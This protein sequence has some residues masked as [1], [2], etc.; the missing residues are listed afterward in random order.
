MAGT[1]SVA[2][3]HKRWLPWRACIDLH[4]AC[5]VNRITETGELHW[6]SALLSLQIAYLFDMYVFCDE[7][8]KATTALTE[9]IADDHFGYE[10]L[11]LDL[12]SESLGA[13]IQRIKGDT[14]EL[15]IVV[16][17]GDSNEAAKH[18][19]HILPAWPGQR[20][21]LTL[22]D[23]PNAGFHWD[24]MTML[25]ADEK[26][27]LMFLFPEDMDI[28]RNA[29]SEARMPKGESRYD[30]YFAEHET[31][32][33]IALDPSVQHT[34]PLLRALYKRD[35]ER[36]LDYQFFGA[37]DIRVSN[38]VGEI[39]TLLFCSKHVRGKELWDKVN[40]P[41]HQQD[42]LYPIS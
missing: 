32:R 20:Y 28:E 16:I 31:W 25:T 30:R 22:I 18:I 15:K 33:S 12:G 8:R 7:S 41:E 38:K 40:R 37:R 23:P 13:D 42:E 1:A 17:T 21:C 27:D 5:G 36:L 24:A 34:G 11:A 26:M 2:M 29:V 9:R 6:G 35:M 3:R 10:P 19:R 39:Y 4:A 14:S